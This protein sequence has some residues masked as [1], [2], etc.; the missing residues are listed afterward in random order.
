MSIS[1]TISSYVFPALLLIIGGIILLVGLVQGQNMW[2][3]LSSALIAASG[4]IM[5][6]FQMGIIGRKG[7]AIIGIV[8]ALMAVLF[9]YQDYR[10][11]AD[12]LRM[13]EEHKENDKLVI[14]ALK[15]MRTAQLAYKQANQSYTA[16]AR[17]LTEF[18]RKGT[19]PVIRAIGQ[20]PDTLSE[21]EA[22]AL[23]IIVRDTIQVSP[24]D[25]LFLSP[26]AIAGRVYEFKVDELTISPTSKKPFIMEAGVVPSSGRNIPVF[27]VKDPSPFPGTEALQVGGMEKPSTSGNWTGE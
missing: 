13:E 8:A 7:G 23:N 26:S 17:E 25:S 27:L 5:L 1:R 11:V 15:D 4:A 14:Q 3:V 19:M 18:I 2:V 10:S 20:K 16:D 21:E 24:L 22:I 12:V 9:A 6:L